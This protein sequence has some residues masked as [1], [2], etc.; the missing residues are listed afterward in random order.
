MAVCFGCTIAGNLATPRYSEGYKKAEFNLVD[1]QGKISVY[2]DQPAWLKSPVDIRPALTKAVK[3]SLLNKALITRDRLVTYAELFK[4]KKVLSAADSSNPAKIA[5]A[6]GAEYLLVIEVTDFDLSTFAE[7]D[8]FNG[9]LQVRAS[10]FD[11]DAKKLWPG[12]EQN[13]KIT[14][15]IESE[16]GT[17]KTSVEM[18]SAAAAHCVTRYLYNCSNARFD[19]PEEKKYDQYSW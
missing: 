10:L 9:T 15:T 3:F 11:R 7:E 12:S 6:V 16:K 17:A 19:I 13:R 5:A 14:V 18:L 2:V 4:A 1:T 8:L